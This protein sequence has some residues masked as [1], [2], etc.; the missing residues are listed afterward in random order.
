MTTTLSVTTLR[1]SASLFTGLEI[2]DVFGWRGLSRNFIAKSFVFPKI[3]C[4]ITVLKHVESVSIIV[5][6][7]EKL[8]LHIRERQE[9]ASG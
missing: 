6:M 5:K 9:S 4:S 7:T 8:Y 1:K 3:L 2:G